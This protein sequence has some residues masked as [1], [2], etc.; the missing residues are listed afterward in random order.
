MLLEIGPH[1]AARLTV[2]DP[3]STASV[4]A[5]RTEDATGSFL[6]GEQFK[7]DTLHVAASTILL[8][9]RAHAILPTVVRPAPF[10]SRLVALRL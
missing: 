10:R 4:S 6:E 8:T 9:V 1:P 5:S 2:S 3:R 7:V